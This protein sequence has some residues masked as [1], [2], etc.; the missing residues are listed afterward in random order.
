MKVSRRRV[1]KWAGAAAAGAVGTAV[2]WSF[3]EPRWP[4]VTAPEIFV[5]R[6][7]AEFDGLRIALV[8][9]VHH[10]RHFSLERVRRTVRCV[11]EL[12]VDVVA[13]CGD[14]VTGREA[15]GGVRIAPSVGALSELRAELGVFAVLGNH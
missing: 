6:L 3:W 2:G 5:P 15:R 11:N 9:D 4:E 7:P 13:L 10:G 12:R 14:Y 1:L 8:A